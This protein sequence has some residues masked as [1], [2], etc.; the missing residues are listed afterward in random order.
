MTT[1]HLHLALRFLLWLLLCSLPVTYAYAAPDMDLKVAVEGDVL[2]CSASLLNPPEGMGRALSEGSEISVEWEISVEIKRK[3]W[4][5]N[6]VA[7]VVV[8]RHV[9]PDLVSQSWKLE[10]RTSGISRRVFSL[11]EAINF[12]TKLP[13]FPIVDR[14]LLASGQV[15]VVVVTVSKREGGGKEEWWTGWF[16]AKSGKA[17]AELLMP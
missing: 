12:L 9:V 2:T 16:G 3:Y 6:T 7:S 5:N 14:S 4:L 13:N 1:L 8:N 15:Y 11:D 10:D 17:A